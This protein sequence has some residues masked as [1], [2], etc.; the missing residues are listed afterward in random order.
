MQVEQEL[1]ALMRDDAFLPV[2]CSTVSSP[3]AT[4]STLPGNSTVHP[5]VDADHSKEEYRD[6]NTER[7]NAERRIRERAEERDRW[8][9]LSDMHFGANSDGDQTVPLEAVEKRGRVPLA[10]KDYKKW[11]TWVPQDPASVEE[12]ELQRRAKEAQADAA[13]EAANAGFVESFKADAARR[14]AVEAEKVTRAARFKDLGNAA[15]KHGK[16][17]AALSAYHDALLLTPFNVALLN[18]LAL[19]H[20]QVA[21]S[22]ESGAIYAALAPSDISELQAPSAVEE[23]I[24]FS[25]RALRVESKNIKA[26]FRRATAFL[27]LGNLAAA[28]M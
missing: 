19:V 8:W 23:A 13:F 14:Q 3:L 28:G 1:K 11:D 6:P 20:L 9:R 24:E 18:N 2:K 15:F 16:L 10:P 17:Q 26:L 5:Y 25:K 27:L 12:A 7:W 22:G 4:A 21:K